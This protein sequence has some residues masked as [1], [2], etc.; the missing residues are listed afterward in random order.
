MILSILQLHI[1]GFIKKKKLIQ[2]FTL[3]AHAFACEPPPMAGLDFDQCLVAYALFT[4]QQTE[5]YLAES[6]DLDELQDKLYRGAYQL[7]REL[8]NELGI[9]T[10]KQAVLM[11]KVIYKMLGIDFASHESNQVVIK[12][13]FFSRYYSPSTCQVISALDKGL[14]AGLSGGGKLE[15]YQR[16]T[17]GSDCCRAKFELEERGLT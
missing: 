13:C 16:I 17:G 8:R 15:F 6:S 5:R 14:A 4:H 3:T 2:L 9:S 10:F 1:P 11:M 12:S 7:G